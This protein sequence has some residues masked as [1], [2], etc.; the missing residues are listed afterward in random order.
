[1][2][3][4]VAK[5]IA[6]RI[7]SGVSKQDVLG[8]LLKE[9]LSLDEIADNVIGVIF[10]AQDTT[11]SVITWVIKYLSENQSLLADVRVCMTSLSSTSL[12]PS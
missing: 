11:A 10:A 5:L 9:N 12:R 6:D 3:T 1:L 7:A 8:R 4:M 2:G